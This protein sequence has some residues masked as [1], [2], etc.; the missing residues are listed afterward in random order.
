MAFSGER[1]PK[2]SPV[3][4]L[5]SQTAECRQTF[6]VGILD[7]RSP[8][9]NNGR[10][11]KHSMQPRCVDAWHCAVETE[12]CC[13]G[14]ESATLGSRTTLKSAPSNSGGAAMSAQS[15]YRLALATC[16]HLPG[17]HPDDA[18]L[19]ISLQRVGIEPTACIWNDP[20]VD[21]SRFDA[22][23]MRTTWDYFMHYTA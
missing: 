7:S 20:A 12:G 16:A 6:R 14:C 5:F 17:I 1:M 21:W 8:A 9:G 4:V 2:N 15:T 22:V 11:S 19:A 10:A 18:Y 3:Q 23:L 13:D